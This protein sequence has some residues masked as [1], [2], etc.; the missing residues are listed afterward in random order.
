MKVKRTFRDKWSKVTV[1]A[2]VIFSVLSVSSFS[3]VN[4]C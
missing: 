4:G 3:L 2:A 1:Y